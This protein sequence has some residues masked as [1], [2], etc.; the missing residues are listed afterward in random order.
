MEENRS[1]QN[2]DTN[3]HLIYDKAGTAE[4]WE[5]DDLSNKWT[6]DDWKSTWKKT[7]LGATSYQQNFSFKRLRVKCKRQN[8]KLFER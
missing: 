5:E 2:T 6:W 8:N 4:Q 7:K 3:E 1:F